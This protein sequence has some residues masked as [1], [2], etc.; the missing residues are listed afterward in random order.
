[1]TRVVDIG[2]PPNE[3]L[4]VMASGTFTTSSATVPAD[5]S[6]TEPD[7][8]FNGCWLRVCGGTLKG[9]IKAITDFTHSTGVITCTLTAVPGLVA[10]EILAP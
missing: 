1:M 9:E 7:D 3:M 10:Y 5:T 6:R 8:F 4:N 2:F